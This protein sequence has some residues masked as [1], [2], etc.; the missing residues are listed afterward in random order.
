MDNL[1]TWLII[2]GAVVSLFSK[3]SGKNN[4]K[5]GVNQQNRPNS[6][7][8]MPDSIQK[9]M[10]GLQ[11]TGQTG[12]NP[13][14]KPPVRPSARPEMARP[15]VRPEMARPAVKPS[16]GMGMAKPIM[17]TAAAITMMEG[18]LVIP[19]G[20]SFGEGFSDE[21]GTSFGDGSKGTEGECDEEHGTI[22]VQR[23]TSQVAVEERTTWSF[24]SENLMSAFVYA[25]ILSA[26]KSRRRQ[27]R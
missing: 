5:P 18:E 2:I 17:G 4:Q 24:N 27:L 23:N 8:S 6:S 12:V 26:P 15:T 11:Q 22:A 25:E 14:M 13:Q 20:Q 3:A 16:M 7:R 21:E 19:Q 9:I 10:E 1:F